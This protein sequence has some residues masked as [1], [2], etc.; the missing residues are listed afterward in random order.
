MNVVLELPE[1]TVTVGGTVTFAL[2]L[3]KI[4]AVPLRPAG[5]DRVTVQVDD[6]GA[7][8]GEGV[9]LTADGVGTAEGASETDVC[10][11]WVP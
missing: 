11:V 8:T 1:L 6:P 3:D 7:V 9:Q 10:C 2:P 4:T 5:L